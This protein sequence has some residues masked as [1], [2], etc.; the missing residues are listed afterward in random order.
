[1]E[2]R[3]MKQ[4]QDTFA[5]IV[6]VLTTSSSDDQKKGEVTKSDDSAKTEPSPYAFQF[7][8]KRWYLRFPGDKDDDFNAKLVGL[9]MY[10]ILLRHKGKSMDSSELRNNAALFDAEGAEYGR[11][12][13]AK[14]KSTCESDVG[15]GEAENDLDLVFTFEDKKEFERQIETFNKQIEKATREGAL[16][17]AA[18]LKKD[19]D[20]LREWVAKS[21]DRHGAPRRIVASKADKDRKAVKKA[22]G[23]SLEI[24]RATMTNMARYLETNCDPDWGAD[25][26]YDPT[27]EIDWDF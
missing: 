15:G 5:G 22:M 3:L 19:R 17:K 4:I 26:C 11:L 23:Y 27:E 1:M 2:D 21:L 7:R 20:K 18:E 6:E 10:F 25:W 24:V 12:L 16:A 13:K 9:T 14:A 8:N